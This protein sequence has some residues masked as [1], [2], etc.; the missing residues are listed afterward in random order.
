MSSSQPGKNIRKYLETHTLDV[1]MGTVKIGGAFARD[2][3][4][5]TK[6]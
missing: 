3:P 6:P 5:P 2:G 1:S 4:G